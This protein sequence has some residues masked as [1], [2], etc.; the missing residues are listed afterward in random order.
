VRR[1][2]RL[3]GDRGKDNRG[4]DV[5]VEARGWEEEAREQSKC[6]GRARKSRMNKGAELR[7]IV[8]VESRE[9]ILPNR[10]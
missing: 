7:P 2:V 1:W 3:I 4:G 10:P 8:R 9:R 6:M 5:F